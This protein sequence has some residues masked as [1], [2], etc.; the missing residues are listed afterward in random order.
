VEDYTV[1]VTGT[2]GEGKIQG[3]V[4]DAETNLAIDAAMITATDAD[5]Q[6]YTTETPFGAHYSMLLPESTYTI[7]CESSGYET[8]TVADVVIIGGE[9]VSQTFYLEPVKTVTGLDEAQ[10][11]QV[12]ISPNPSSNGVKIQSNTEISHLTVINQAGQLV[13]EINSNSK[14]VNVNVSE[15]DSGIYF[16]KIFTHEN[17]ITKKLVIE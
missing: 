17:V 8:G 10:Y 11:S 12:T 5:D 14:I 1:I 7:S 9:N 6:V 3:F 13:Y 4:R 15:F 16:V 2:V